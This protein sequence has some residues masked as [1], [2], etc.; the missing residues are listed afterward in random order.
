MTKKVVKKQDND[1]VLD[2]PTEWFSNTPI[3]F[4]KISFLKVDDY[5]H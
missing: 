1:D 4:P 2:E 3:K 5:P